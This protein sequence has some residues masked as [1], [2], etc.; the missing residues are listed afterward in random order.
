VSGWAADPSRPEPI[1]VILFADD[2]PVAS[3]HPTLPRPDVAQL[4]KN[5]R[6]RQT[7][8][9]FRIRMESALQ[10]RRL[11]VFGVSARGVASELTYAP[12]IR[13]GPAAWQGTH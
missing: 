7:G 4:L 2:R 9:T 11:R 10:T 13:P 12:G 8:Y 5:E 1:S 3:V 6:L